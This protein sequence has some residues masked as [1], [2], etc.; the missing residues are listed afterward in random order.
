MAGGDRRVGSGVPLRRR[1][2]AGRNGRVAREP[3][4]GGVV[5]GASPSSE[6]LAERPA[7]EVWLVGGEVVGVDDLAVGQRQ[8]VS[9][10]VAE[11]DGE[12]R[13]GPSGESGGEQLAVV[14][15]GRR[16]DAF[17]ASPSL[18][19]RLLEGVGW[20]MRRDASGGKTAHLPFRTRP[21]TNRGSLQTNLQTNL[22]TDKP[23]VGLPPRGNPR[24]VS[25]WPRVGLPAPVMGG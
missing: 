13:G 5:G 3:D 18:D 4:V 16:H 9:G 15:A 1:S 11:L 14:G 12:D 24:A 8:P 2:W 6:G 22:Q 7:G 23:L 25:R 20:R 19:A 10:R 17:P 21:A